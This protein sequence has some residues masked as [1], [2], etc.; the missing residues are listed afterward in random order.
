M[1]LMQAVCISK[2]ELY[3]KERT[4]RVSGLR[5]AGGLRRESNTNSGRTAGSGWTGDC[6]CAA[7]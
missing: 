5:D 7:G 6:L 3:E 2:G 1:E 4:R